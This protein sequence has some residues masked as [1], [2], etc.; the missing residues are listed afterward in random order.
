MI[1]SDSRRGFAAALCCSLLLCLRRPRFGAGNRAH[2]APGRTT[3]WPAASRRERRRPQ[4]PRPRPRSPTRRT[5]SPTIWARSSTSCCR[6]TRDWRCW[7]PRKRRS[8]PPIAEQDCLANAVYFEA[9]GEPLEGQL[10]VAEVVLNRAASGRY[11]ATLCASGHPARAILL[12]PPRRHS[13]APTAAPKPGA[14]PSPSRASPRSAR[15]GCF[16]RTCSGIM[17]ITSRRAGAA[18]SP[19]TPRSA[20]TSSTVEAA[21]TAS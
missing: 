8:R 16:P 20:P 5:R 18:A 4:R 9:R 14:A 10:A 1:S 2:P 6:P 21:S 13:R 12:R 11:P 7:S 3:R 17:P 19:A 15:R